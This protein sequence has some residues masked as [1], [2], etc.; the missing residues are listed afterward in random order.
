MAQTTVKNVMIEL[1][2]GDNDNTRIRLDNPINNITRE[3]ISA[4]LQ[5]ALI[6]EWIITDKGS[7][8]IGIGEVVLETSTKVP[9]VGTDYYITPSSLNINTPGGSGSGT[10][11]VSGATIQGYNFRNFA[12]STS[13]LYSYKATIA[14]NGLSITVEVTTNTTTFSVTFDLILVIQGTEVTVPCTIT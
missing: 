10:V 12:G 6:N 3:M 9:L 13:N 1:K 14:N 2:S 5:P 4:A 8:A 11:T 7:K